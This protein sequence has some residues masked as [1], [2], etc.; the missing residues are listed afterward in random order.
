[1]DYDFKKILYVNDLSEREEYAFGYAFSIAKRFS[2]K[3]TVLHVIEEMSPSSS[4]VVHSILGEKQWNE[5]LA[6]NKQLALDAIQKRI[7][8]SCASLCE[9]GEYDEFVE[10]VIVIFG[11]AEEE[12]LSMMDTQGFDLVVLGAHSVTAVGKAL[13]DYTAKHVVRQC[14]KPVLIIHLPRD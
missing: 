8:D 3:I 14:K 7:V 9:D 12:I 11:N 1:M 13:L 6:K 4:S 5:L 10:D 2:A